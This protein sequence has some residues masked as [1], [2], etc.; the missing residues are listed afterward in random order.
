MPLMKGHS[1]EVV[2]S[3]IKEMMKAGHPQK[4]AIAAALSMA[5]KSK[6]MADGGIVGN[7]MDSI[8]GTGFGT[9]AER[10]L[11][12]LQAQ[13]QQRPDE[14]SNPE[15]MSEDQMLAKALFKRAESEELHMAM[16]GLVEGS[17]DTAVG[18]KPKEAMGAETGEPMS[19]LSDAGMTEA[20]MDAIMKKKK[21][22]RFVQ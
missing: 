3:N 19:D 11:G 21:S 16:G 10:T 7:D 12:E 17:S 6:K 18:T 8:A 22:R 1:K 13:A 15:S 5:R 4:Q 9:E 20:Q 2:S 14:I